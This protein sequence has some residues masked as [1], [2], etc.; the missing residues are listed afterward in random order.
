MTFIP[1]LP[2]NCLS[3]TH[4]KPKFTKD[5]KILLPTPLINKSSF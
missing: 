3:F 4:N 1:A 5:E 2:S